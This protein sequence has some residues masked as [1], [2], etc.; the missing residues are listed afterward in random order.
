MLL[1]GTLVADEIDARILQERIVAL[2]LALCLQQ[3]RRVRPRIDDRQQIAL[4]DE[5]PFLEMHFRDLARHPA[6][7]GDGVDRGDRPQGVD[8]H[9]DV[10][11]RDRRDRN[12]GSGLRMRRGLGPEQRRAGHP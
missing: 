11:H 3:R 6:H 1:V 10:A 2:Q 8:V 7:D 9:V 4:L 5:L 12:R